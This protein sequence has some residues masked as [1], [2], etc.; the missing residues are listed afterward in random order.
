MA[1]LLESFCVFLILKR[2][3]PVSFSSL[4]KGESAKW[5]FRGSLATGLD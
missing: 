2:R 3:K 5:D 1:T 4:E